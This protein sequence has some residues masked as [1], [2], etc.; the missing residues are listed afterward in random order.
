MLY[1][2]RYQ[3]VLYQVLCHA[4]LASEFFS[5]RWCIIVYL[6]QFLLHW[7]CI[8]Y[9]LRGAALVQQVLQPVQHDTP[10]LY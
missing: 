9:V 7:T 8:R 5:T 6:V 2:S 1:V 10:S 4:V 3:I